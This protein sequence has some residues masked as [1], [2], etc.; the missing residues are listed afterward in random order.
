MTVETQQEISPAE[1]SRAYPEYLATGHL[2]RIRRDDFA[3][4]DDHDLV[5]VDYAGSG[6][7][8]RSQVAAF[9]R[10]LCQE[11]LGNPHSENAPSRRSSEAMRRARR[12][13][14]RFLN[15]DPDE[16]SVI[17]TAN[18]TGALRL[19]GEAFPFRPGSRFA[20]LQDNHNSVLGIREYAAARGATL[21]MIPLR[22]DLRADPAAVIE[23]LD[24]G[25]TLPSLFAYPAQSNFSGV[26]HPLGWIHE[27]RSRGWRVVLDAAAYA[28]V[29]DLDLSSD[30]P[31]FVPLSYYKIFGWPTGLGCLVARNDA[32]AELR[33][34]WF[35]G[36][37]VLAS[38]ALGGWHAP[39]AAPEGFEDGTPDFTGVL[40]VTIGLDYVRESLG[41]DAVRTRLGCLMDRLLDVMRTLRHGNGLP[42]CT[43]YGPADTKDRGATIAFNLL[44][45]DGVLVDERAVETSA[46]HSGIALRAGCFCNPGVGETIF[47]LDPEDLLRA[48][49]QRPAPATADEYRRAMRLPT[50]G[51][52][53]ISLGPMSNLRDISRL[54]RF[55]KSW[56][57]Y[58]AADDDLSRLGERARC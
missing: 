48:G 28:A 36:G 7:P 9:Q 45:T 40:G 56:R 15:A 57:D 2:D 4:L 17:F 23:A 16:Y 35:S 20:L 34:P 5:Y 22:P 46:A 55:L 29:S 19:V 24:R 11:T 47:A 3:R 8:G 18:A 52:L 32:L 13:T 14:L 49:R 39:A 43:V 26:Q 6:L 1:F 42:V 44:D 25:S 51:A 12:A 41:R 54:I 58:R 50:G 38:S 21:E 30:K 27:A 37:T 53:R 33:R 31:D 10:L